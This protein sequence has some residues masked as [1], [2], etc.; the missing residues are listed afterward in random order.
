MRDFHSNSPSSFLPLLPTH[1][2]SLTHQF[3]SREEGKTPE[4][5]VSALEECSDFQDLLIALPTR[6]L[7]PWV[8]FWIKAPTLRNLGIRGGGGSMQVCGRRKE[9]LEE[10]LEELLT[11]VARK[12][13]LPLLLLHPPALHWLMMRNDGLGKAEKLPLRPPIGTGEAAVLL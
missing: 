3:R 13:V 4:L 12:L 1:S 7:G 5:P 8:D 2:H 9:F 6:G 10:D 11:R